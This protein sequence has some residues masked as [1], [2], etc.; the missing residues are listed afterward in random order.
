MVSK[1]I[2]IVLLILAILFTI[3]SI[4]IAVSNNTPKV[5]SENNDNS[6]VNPAVESGKVSLIINPNPNTPK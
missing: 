2:V 5:I 4:A 3:A 6:N 1:K